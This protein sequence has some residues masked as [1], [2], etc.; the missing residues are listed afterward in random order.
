M[1]NFKKSVHDALWGSE[2]WEISAHLSDPSVIADGE[3][4]GRRLNEIYP[5]FPLLFKVINA[6]TRLS[7]Q[8]HPNEVTRQV[9]GGD[10]KTEM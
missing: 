3:K 7:V 6:R 9:T 8:V 1:M 4:K 10:P 2:S 5:K